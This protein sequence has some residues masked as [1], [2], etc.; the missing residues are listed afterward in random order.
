[1][2]STRFTGQRQQ[3]VDQLFPNGIPMLWCPS[4]T[5]FTDDG[6]IDKTRMRAHLKFMYPSVQ[7][8]LIPGSTG[9]G[10]EMSDAEVRA[11]LDFMIDEIRNV[12]A[13][14]LIGVLKTDIREVLQ[15]VKDTVAWLQ[16][17]AGT[18]DTL[19]SLRKSSVCGFTVCPPSGS[20]LSQE[21]IRTALESVLS[22][23]VPVSLYQLPQVTQNEMSPETVTALS[24]KFPNF[25]LFKDTS[26]MDRVAA[27]G[28]RGAFL[29]R[30]AE[31]GY[32]NHLAAGGGNYDGFLLSTANCFGR[33]LSAMIEN[34]QRGKK[35][36]AEAFSK[37][38]SVLCEEVFDLAGKVGYGN[39]FTNA[40]KAMDHFFAHGPGAA[41]VA[42]PRLYSGKRL[43]KELI[44]AAGAALK[45]NGLMPESGYLQPG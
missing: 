24:A 41:Q 13:H 30:G 15:S 44:E 39:A 3:L 26:G 4:L 40:N 32:A 23:G 19:E 6:A 22:L 35:E 31:G 16:Q 36:E 11:L 21:Q 8:F 2:N 14:L 9:E 25:Y 10:W 37:K 27:A 43:P 20:E 17:R 12:G 45:R 1:M 42:P 18:V 28:F 5:H 34:V 38:L 7:G 29:V 33:E